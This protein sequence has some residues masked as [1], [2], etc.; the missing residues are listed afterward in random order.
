M[1]VSVRTFMYPSCSFVIFGDHDISPTEAHGRTNA[2]KELRLDPS[3]VPR[4]SPGC[5][6]PS[7]RPD[8]ER[9]LFFPSNR[10]HTHCHSCRTGPLACCAVMSIRLAKGLNLVL[11]PSSGISKLVGKRKVHW[12]GPCRRTKADTRT[13]VGNVLALLL[14]DVPH[15]RWSTR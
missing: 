10:Q 9:P 7:L 5:L 8:P 13:I 1:Y 14:T 15:S 2:H 12:F 11:L 6:I 3:N 4:F